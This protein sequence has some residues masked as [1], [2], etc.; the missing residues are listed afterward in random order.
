MKYGTNGTST[1]TGPRND[2]V[3]LPLRSRAVV[4]HKHH[5]DS[6]ERCRLV[7]RLQRCNSRAKSL[8]FAPI[9][10]SLP[11]CYGREGT[12]R[13]RKSSQVANGGDGIS[14]VAKVSLA[15][16][17]E[18]TADAAVQSA[19]SA[20]DK[21][22]QDTADELQAVGP[23]GPGL[24]LNPTD[25]ACATN[26]IKDAARKAA[27]KAVDIAISKFWNKSISSLMSMGRKTLRQ[28]LMKSV[29]EAASKAADEA[30]L[31]SKDFAKDI[32]ENGIA[33][34][35]VK[36][37]SD[38]IATKAVLKAM[39]QEDGP[40]SKVLNAVGAKEW[41]DKASLSY[42]SKVA[43]RLMLAL[44][45]DNATIS[46][47]TSTLLGHDKKSS[48]TGTEIA[49]MMATLGLMMQCMGEGFMNGSI[50]SK[51][52]TA[53][54]TVNQGVQTG[55]SF[56][57]SGIDKAQADATT[58]LQMTN[59]VFDLLHSLWKQIHQDVS[60]DAGHYATLQ[61]EENKRI[62]ALSKHMYDGDKT[63][64]QVLMSQ[65]V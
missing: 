43:S 16:T 33:N 19:A 4:L 15:Q 51:I 41:A 46:N 14:G 28:E 55:T 39:K 40:M 9:R 26:A 24:T 61:K 18:E 6:Y 23:V 11:R 29:E 50:F 36:E 1:Q 5:H 45:F 57:M 65:A 58:G 38:A 54:L 44:T 63:G 64:V 52:Q 60:K 7:W 25:T 56:A 53:A 49:Q 27:K 8:N 30:V 21:T 12:R 31:M 34:V 2:P 13:E 35:S 3:D 22:V 32:M 62:N 59:A 17:V 20:I 48:D 47:F 10:A 37:G 42:G